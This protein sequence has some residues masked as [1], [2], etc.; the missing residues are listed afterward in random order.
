MP[1]APS[2]PGYLIL[3]EK[4]NS[5]PHLLELDTPGCLRG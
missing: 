5:K 1:V 3:E 2:N 4:G